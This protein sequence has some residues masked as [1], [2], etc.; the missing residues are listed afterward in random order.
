[1][2]T[3]LSDG[4]PRAVG[5]FSLIEVMVAM[6]I[7]LVL[8][9]GAMQ[10]YINSRATYTVNETSARLQETA[11]YALSVMEPD[12]R[13]AGY[14][15]V[16]KEAN[17][18]D[19]WQPQ[20]PTVTLPVPTQITTECGF[21][22]AVDL[23]RPV[24]GSNNAFA[25]GVAPITNCNTLNNNPRQ[26][27]DTL[28]VRH[29]SAVYTPPGANPRYHLC[30]NRG[31]GSLLA[32]DQAAASCVVP[33]LLSDF[34]VTGYYVSNDSSANAGGNGVPSL[35]YMD[36]QTGAVPGFTDVEVIQGV[37]DLQVQI[38]F[39]PN[40]T[41]ATSS[42]PRQHC[43]MARYYVNPNGPMP[44]GATSAQAVSVRVWLLVR[45][46]TAEGGFVDGRLYQY[47]DRLAATGVTSDLA[48]AGSAGRAY[49]PSGNAQLAPFRRLLVSRTFQLR[50]AEGTESY[51]NGVANPC[52]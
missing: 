51:A 12:I 47:A 52:P 31:G 40:F 46:D 14:W 42:A 20:L 17:M 48:T 22:Y 38:G 5:G 24:Q 7:G 33:N 41:A 23:S 27:S 19:G 9:A 30:S 11:R 50:N 1:M 43:G 39:E 3:T 15:G 2:K 4:T 37:E 10:V 13:M 44:A 16:A 26:S 18:V 35:R 45:A 32:A 34:K 8:V 29:A 6:V 36:L 25:L 28:T 49:R 21:N